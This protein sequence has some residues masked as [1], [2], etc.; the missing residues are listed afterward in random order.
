MTADVNTPQAAR[1]LVV[2]DE[3]DLLTLYELSLL[4]EGHQ[5]STA[6]TVLEARRLLETQQFD[7]LIT[8]MRLPDGD[9]L[10]LLR[11]L[12]QQRRSERRIMITAYGSAETAVEALKCGAFDY[13]TKPVDLKQL[14]SVVRAALQAAPAVQVQQASL[15]PVAAVQPV[16]PVAA[17]TEGTHTDKPGQAALARLVGDSVPMQQVKQRIA[18]V[19]RSMAP[20]LVHGESGTGKELVAFAVHACSHRHAGPFVPVNCGAIP[21]NLLEAEFFGALKG[22]YTGAVQDREGFFQAAAGG[23]LFLDEIGDLPLAMQAKLLRAIQER[24]VRPLGATQEQPVDVRIVSATHKHLA[25][26]VEVGRF[27]QDLYYRLNVIEIVIPPLRERREDIPA[28]SQV[29]LGRIAAETGDTELQL[30]LE[31]LAEVTQAPLPGNVRELE[32]LLHRMVALGSS[33]DVP[34]LAPA[35]PP[36]TAIGTGLRAHPAETGIHGPGQGT[37]ELSPT[38]VSQGAVPQP[39]TGRS[40]L[41]WLDAQE[42]AL[43]LQ[44][45][46]EV[47][48]NLPEAA[49]RLGLSRRQLSCRLQRLGLGG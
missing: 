38:A 33:R 39:Q 16:T 37:A 48:S 35:G 27:R 40:L 36:Q 2:D 14:R 10:Q 46:G 19:A 7:L 5:V 12:A 42:H 8:D 21:E 43:L 15:A 17:L 45:L 9:G 26:E 29:L 31:Q 28:I 1:I 44:V 30:S 34:V 13:L 24:C 23:T 3:P 41:D 6:A 20:V 25:H 18:K 4:R 11:E 49:E 22:S 32:N 47:G